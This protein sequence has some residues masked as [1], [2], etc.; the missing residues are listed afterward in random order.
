MTTTMTPTAP[1]VVEAPWTTVT[2]HDRIDGGV[3][4]R[5]TIKVMTVMQLEAE[6][7]R[8]EFC[9]GDW[10]NK[11]HHRRHDRVKVFTESSKE[12]GHKLLITEGMSICG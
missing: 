5:R 1:T 6:Q 4:G 3:G 11:S 7:L 8:V 2:A 9:Q 10:L 12:I